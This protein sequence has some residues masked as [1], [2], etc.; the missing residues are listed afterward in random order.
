MKEK[1]ELLRTLL[2]I[3]SDHSGGGQIGME[4]GENKPLGQH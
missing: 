2:F 4:L 3:S 1:V